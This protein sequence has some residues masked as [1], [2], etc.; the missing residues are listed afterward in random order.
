[1]K[2]AWILRLEVCLVLA[3]ILGDS[4]PVSAFNRTEDQETHV[5]LWWD[6][7]TVRFYVN[8]VCCADIWLKQNCMNAVDVSME[9]WDQPCTDLALVVQGT[10]TRTDI[11]FD[12][13]H[14]SQNINLILWIKSGWEHE[15]SAIAVTT[16]TYNVID[17]KIV[18]ADIELNDETFTFT[19]PP[20]SNTSTDVQN[21]LVHEFGHAIGLDHSTDADAS[22][23]PSATPRETKKRDLDSDDINGLCF[24]YP[25]GG[26]TPESGDDTSDGGCNCGPA[27]LALEGAMEAA[28]FA[29]MLLYVRRRK[30]DAVQKP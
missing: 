13:D 30:F 6:N 2:S 17:G 21:T 4:A 5:H 29:A 10:T 16:T 23:F 3:A 27:S 24:V 1:M 18:D 28:V 14:W 7:R 11:G 26:P 25:E 8:E 12:Q 9:A 20:D 19:A 15:S 22:M